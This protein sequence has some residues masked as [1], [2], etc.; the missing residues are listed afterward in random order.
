MLACLI[1][2]LAAALPASRAHAGDGD[3][4][5]PNRIE[6][7]AKKAADGVKNTVKRTGN[8]AQRT[9][10]RAGKAVGRAAERTDRW[11]RKKLE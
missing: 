11:I 8:W 5:K 7:A 6:R 2:S 4:E 10:E 1:A 9:G 3:S